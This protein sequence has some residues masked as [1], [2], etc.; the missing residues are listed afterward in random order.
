MKDCSKCGLWSA[1]SAKKCRHCGAWFADAPPEES[2]DEENG[3]TVKPADGETGK[4]STGNWRIEKL[5]IYVFMLLGMGVGMLI[6]SL[7]RGDGTVVVVLS[8]LGAVG[9]I[10]I[11]RWW[12]CEDES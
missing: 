12:W 2:V 10:F 6:D 5:F 11:Y 9:G 8:V 7:I 1:D 4:R 3:S